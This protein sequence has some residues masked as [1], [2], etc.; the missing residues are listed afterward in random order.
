MTAHGLT[1]EAPDQG[2]QYCGVP[3]LAAL[4]Q[5]HRHALRITVL[6]AGV[7]WL[8]AWL[9][10]SLPRMPGP[11]VRST[12][13]R[14]MQA[15][16]I[17][18]TV[19]PVLPPAAAPADPGT[20]A[21]ADPALR[22]APKPVP[23][24]AALPRPTPP[25]PRT[26]ATRATPAPSP[27]PE[28]AQPSGGEALPTYATRLPPGA[29]LQYAVLREGLGPGRAGIQAELRWRPEGEAYTLTLGLANTGWASV[30]AIDSH[31][32]APE[33]HV[34]TRRG[35]EV[36]AANFQ[37]QAGRITFSGP[38]LEYPLLPGA[39]DRLSW[40][41][42]LASVMAADPALSEVGREVQLF[43]AGV[44]GDAGLWTFTVTGTE[45]AELPAGRVP[46]TVHLHRE[47][48]RP[49]DTRVDIWLDP[50]RHHLPVRIRMQNRG[51]GEATD[52][53]LATLELG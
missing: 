44:R 22:P 4:T 21:M 11:E 3:T 2:W 24:P 10:G 48:Q 20:Q 31:G 32:L 46:G 7:L 41:L 45:T 28:A 6:A 18:Q 30:G 47:P 52:F 49:Y 50:A 34:E 5:G 9:L 19:L 37:R 43:V 17:V 14:P 51:E 36:R 53:L 27:A 12:A 1:S 26:A 15:R 39:Q 13:P 16:Q 38:Q 8:H 29:T 42:Q 33:R 25:V 23:E 40:M 35:R